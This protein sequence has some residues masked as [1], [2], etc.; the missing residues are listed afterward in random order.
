MPTLALLLGLAVAKGAVKV[1]LRDDA[2]AQE[3]GLELHALLGRKISDELDRRKAARTFDRLA[4]E[5]SSRLEPFLTVE[6]RGLADNERSAATQA[7][8]DTLDR[9]PLTVS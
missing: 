7:V 9:A 3:V 5:I 6:F 2:L 4:E 8:I 1:W